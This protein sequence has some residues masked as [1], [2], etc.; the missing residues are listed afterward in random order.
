MAKELKFI[1]LGCRRKQCSGSG[2]FIPDPNFVHP[3]SRVKTQ[4]DSSS[5]IR[6]RIKKLSILN[7]KIVA[8][9]SEI[10]FE[11]FILDPDLDFDVLPIRDTG[12]KKAPDPGSGSAT[13]GGRIITLHMIRQCLIESKGSSGILN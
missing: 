6:I 8:K 5:R 1:V 3:G 11:M 7:P 10:W 9:L 13:L 4:K 2:M 12:V